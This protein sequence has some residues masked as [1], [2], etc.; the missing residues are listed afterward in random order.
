MFAS[1]FY[2]HDQPVSWIRSYD[3]CVQ[4]LKVYYLQVQ[5]CL[6]TV[7]YA[8]VDAFLNGNRES[9]SSPLLQLAQFVANKS[10]FLW[11]SW[12]F[13]HSCITNTHDM[14]TLHYIWTY[15]FLDVLAELSSDLHWIKNIQC[16][17]LQDPIKFHLPHFHHKHLIG[18]IL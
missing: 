1:Q 6:G 17:F 8:H 16:K 7:W 13:C 12:P 11:T 4:H 3:P 5:V 18:K 2:Y 14:S 9:S 10:S 15:N